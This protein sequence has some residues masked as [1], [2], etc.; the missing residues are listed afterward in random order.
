MDNEAWTCVNDAGDGTDGETVASTAS[1]DEDDN[2]SAHGSALSYDRSPASS[3]D[4]YMT[5]RA[6]VDDTDDE[7]D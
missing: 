7:G 4:G 3:T 5:Y 2:L 6:H 1:L